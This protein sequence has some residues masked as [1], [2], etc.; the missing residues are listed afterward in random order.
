MAGAPV[1]AEASAAA[2]AAPAADVD[3]TPDCKLRV[4]HVNDVY[5]L[6]HLP[7]LKS[8][9]EN[10]GKGAGYKNVLT[11][12][13]GDFLGPSLL[14]SLDH[15]T[16]MVDCL[17]AVPV[18]AVCF[19]NH[20]TD[21]PYES[22]KKRIK[23]Y[24]G[25]WINSNMPSFKPEL[26]THHRVD[27]DGGRSVVLMGFNV[28]ER[29]LYRDGAFDG[30]A[31]EIQPILECAR[32]AT[33]AAM[34][35]EPTA[36][37]AIALTHQDMLDDIE[38]AKQGLFP[39]ILGGHDHSV[40]SKQVDGKC[41]VVKSGED[42]KTL[43]VIDLV[44]PAGAP[45]GA[46]PTVEIA[47]VIP[48]AP[49]KRKKGEIEALPFELRFEKDAELVERVA[50]WMAPAV[51]LETSTLEKVEYT[52]SEDV[53]TSVGVRRGPA[54]MASLIATALRDNCK[55]D[56]AMI[57]A[58]GV[59]GKRDYTNGIVTYAHLNAECPFPSSNVVL[60]LDG[61]TFSDAVAASRATWISRPGE[62]D[63]EAF[64]C[65]YGV[66]TDTETHAVTH[67]GGEPLDPEKM[68]QVVCDAYMVRV[69]LVLKAYAAE[70]PDRIPPD[71]S[72]QPALP[73]LVSYFCN[74][75]WRK[76][77]D[78]DG[79]GSI[80]TEEVD[81]FFDAAD[82]NKDGVLIEE[83]VVRAMS[84]TLGE[85]MASRV[86]ARRM[87]SLADRDHNGKVS[88]EELHAVLVET[89]KLHS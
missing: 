25:A 3:V 18:D 23:E 7:A 72:G 57:N 24:K 86:V 53:L 2:D 78:A 32:G 10:L 36:D 17:N 55:A 76:L 9:V 28:H 88:R 44:W 58:G 47:D 43:T 15:G 11:T 54:S 19:G 60:T 52:E 35:A 81:K 74:K 84:E 5:I 75:A 45:Q 80:A 56:A 13:A 66:T 27:L 30:A 85:F 70:H 69:N 6:D 41:W 37:I 51:E 16:G 40:Q 64:H 1:G 26:P 33:E 42:A 38:L 61:K 48:L 82:V 34:A 29:T 65:D 59:R 71:D 63:A 22:L 73:I 77:T 67:V 49:P 50:K 46:W 79:D 87:L 14:S 83:E 20:E 8:H 31:A 39:L 62:E 4:F 89:T 68:Y 21:V 12:L